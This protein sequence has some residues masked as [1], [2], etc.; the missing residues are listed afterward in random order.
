[1]QYKRTCSSVRI[2]ISSGMK[3]CERDGH[4]DPILIIACLIDKDNYHCHQEEEQQEAPAFPYLYK[5]LIQVVLDKIAADDKREQKPEHA[6]GGPDKGWRGRQGKH[7]VG[8]D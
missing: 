4:H 5:D 2:I 1:M 8:H 3:P 7:D 6:K